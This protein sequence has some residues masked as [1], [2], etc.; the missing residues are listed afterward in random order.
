MNAECMSY[1]GT[2]RQLETVI[3]KLETKRIHEVLI[4]IGIPPNIL[5]YCFLLYAL[6]L[7]MFN[8]NYMRGITTDLY[9]A[10]AEKF[11]STPARVE[12]DMRHAIMVA[13]NRGD[14]D[15]IYSVF[16]NCVDP[17]RGVPSN[18][19]FLSRVYYHITS[20]R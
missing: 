17:N 2:N 9:P 15:Y 6:E 8:P 5:G 10:I 3:F 1:L 20:E 11:G 7:I 19:L 4:R 12:R 13:W 16:K 14:L 18:S